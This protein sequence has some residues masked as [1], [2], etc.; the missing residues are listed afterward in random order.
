MLNRCQK[1]GQKM[2]IDEDRTTKWELWLKCRHTKKC[3]H[4]AM[5][6]MADTF[7]ALGSDWVMGRRGIRQLGVYDG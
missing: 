5:F 1:C 2:L 4:S 7:G 6:R 3:G